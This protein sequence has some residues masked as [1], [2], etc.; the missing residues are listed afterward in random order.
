MSA[1]TLIQGQKIVLRLYRA[2]EAAILLATTHIY[3][4]TNQA[5]PTSSLNS[6]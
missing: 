2:E 3:A 4:G 1:M 5:S 6:A